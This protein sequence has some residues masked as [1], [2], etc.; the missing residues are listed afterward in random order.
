MF[1]DIFGLEFCGWFSKPLAIFCRKK[2]GRL[3]V[4][5]K[6]HHKRSPEIAGETIWNNE[7]RYYLFQVVSKAAKTKFGRRYWCF[8][9]TKI[10]HVFV[11][12]S[13]QKWPKKMVDFSRK[14]AQD[15]GKV[16][17]PE[18]FWSSF[19]GISGVMAQLKGCP[20]SLSCP[21]VAYPATI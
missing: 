14:T 8:F 13:T 12:D 15:I 21:M 18:M 20:W 1:V 11:G 10:N 9:L 7:I 19:R 2:T 17:N 16:W 4:K 6:D 3:F 5:P